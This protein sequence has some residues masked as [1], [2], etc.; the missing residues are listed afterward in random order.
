MSENLIP[1]GI[2]IKVDKVVMCISLQSLFCLTFYTFIS[3]MPVLGI[4]KCQF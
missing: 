1:G 3:P 2:L 4:K